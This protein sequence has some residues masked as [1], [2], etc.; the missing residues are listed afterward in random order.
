MN[1]SKKIPVYVLSGFLG[2][3]KTTVLLNMLKHCKNK[4]LQ[5]G[6]ILNEIGKTNVEGHL[7]ENQKVFELLDGCICCTIQD[8]LKETMNE[9]IIEMEQSPLDVLLIEGTGVANPMEIQEVLLSHPYNEQFDLMSIITVLDASHYLE[10]QSIF[11]SSTEVRNLMHEQ[12]ICGS[13]LV[14]NKTDL[15]PSNQLAKIKQKITKKL[16]QEKTIV[17]CFFGKVDAELLFE[18]RIH[19]FSIGKTSLDSDHHPHHSSLQALKLEDL[20]VVQKKEF[21]QWLKHLPA[22]VL[23]G[24]GFI[25]IEGLHQLYSFQYASRRVTFTPV[26]ATLNRKPVIILIGMGLSLEQ[27]KDHL[28][29]VKQ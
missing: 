26:P 3:G 9:L 2:S 5:P 25:E 29:L 24:K 13:L 10:Y 11:S 28:K 16:Q 6:I 12:M 22:N 14:L 20:P 19:S 21:E 4:G 18:K 15:V 7:F 23:R 27:I 17:E 1:S 8:D